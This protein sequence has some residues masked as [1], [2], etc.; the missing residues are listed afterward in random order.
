MVKR[1]FVRISFIR[2]PKITSMPN[3]FDDDL[4]AK[5]LKAQKKQ[6]KKK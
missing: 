3:K 4:T 5:R 1:K 6:R 2:K